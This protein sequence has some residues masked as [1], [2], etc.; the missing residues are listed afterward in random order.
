MKTALILSVG[1]T[2]EPLKKAVDEVAGCSD[3]RV[4]LLYGRP[5][6]DQHP[7]PFQ[8]AQEVLS[9]AEGKGIRAETREISEPEDFDKVLEV[10]RS[11]LRE[12]QGFDKVIVNYTGGTKAMSAA[13]AHAA[14]TSDIVGDLELHYVGGQVRDK[15]GRVMVMEIRRHQRTLTHERVRQVLEAVKGHR[16]EI[17][18]NLADF[19]PDIGKAGFV[20]RAA[21]AF[22][23]WDGFDYEGALHELRQ[24]AQQAKALVDDEEVGFVAKTVK[25]LVATANQIVNSVRKLRELSGGEAKEAPPS[26]DE[27]AL[28]CA[29]VLE[30]AER[31]RLRR[32]FNEAVLRSYR[33]LEVAVQGALLDKGVNPWKPNW[34]K[35]SEEAKRAVE[36]QMGKLPTDLALWA[37][38]LTWQVLT[39]EVLTGEEEKRLK[40]LQQTRNL[41][42][43]EHGYRPCDRK[44]A[45]R[46]IC[47]AQSLSEKVLG[48]G[49][50]RFREQVRLKGQLC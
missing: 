6:P 19:L 41:S 38:L 43:L 48:R 23:N 21:K 26:L 50:E 39:G 1:T 13:L 18:G 47:Y 25:N 8:V 37:G 35:V 46:C 20:K 15:N 42:I 49:L 11:V 28:L 9:H 16:Y 17:A 4:F 14:L 30:N 2:S 33:A 32:Q 24:I 27:I 36:S 45:E 40:D 5:F 7:N 10:A 22:L 3:V 34:G 29:D 12:V 44:D 31:C